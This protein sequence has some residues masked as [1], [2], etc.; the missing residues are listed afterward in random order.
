[1]NANS[2]F[3]LRSVPI[4]VPS[5]PFAVNKADVSALEW[6]IDQLVYALYGLTPEEIKIVEGAT[7][8]KRQ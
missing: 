6:E 3:H 8:N 5:H 7:A 2:E 4:R 1:M